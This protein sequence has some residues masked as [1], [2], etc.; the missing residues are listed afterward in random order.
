M[1]ATSHF[2][3]NKWVAL[4]SLTVDFFIG[5]LQPNEHHI[6]NNCIAFIQNTD[7]STLK[8]NQIIYGCIHYKHDE[9][10]NE[11]QVFEI[12]DVDG[13]SHIH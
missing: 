5:K 8:E 9:Y 3:N 4:P 10:C 1:I 13:E 12:K 6:T 7:T 11:Y 2:I